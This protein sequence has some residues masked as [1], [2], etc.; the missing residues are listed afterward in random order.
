MWPD[1]RIAEGEAGVEGRS[2]RVLIVHRKGVFAF[3]GGEQDQV[4]NICSALE[5]LG[6]QIELADSVPADASRF[7]LV[8]FFGLDVC[9]IEEI[10][11][12]GGVP[13]VLTPVFWDR[14]QGQLMDDL[15]DE[16]PRPGKELWDKLIYKFR[17]A[18]GLQYRRIA[19]TALGQYQRNLGNY[20]R[21]QQV[22]DSVDIFLP[23]SEAEMGMLR[24]FY[25]INDPRYA[26]VPNAV[27]VDALDDVSDFA[28]KNLRIC[29]PFI[30][31]SGGI[32]RRKNQ[33]VLLKALLNTDVPVVFAGSVRDRRYYEAIVRLAARRSGV[34]FLGHLSRRDLYSVL[35]AAA[36]HA[37]PA[38]H[39]TP[40]IANLEAVA[41]GC[42]N[43]ATQIGGLREYLGEYS[44]YCNPFSLDHIRETVLHALELSPDPEG[45][46]LVRT[47]YTYQQAAAATFDAY[48]QLLG[49]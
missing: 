13:K 24:Q 7:D 43:V 39:D 12:A 18:S 47:R 3:E 35:K 44:L 20:G 21:F 42:V 5:K 19:L 23:N 26:V 2:L 1:G 14:A 34:H 28:E 46:R 11:R 9:H 37:L 31:C 38:F 32:D 27:D 17:K 36:V 6:V 8:H 45:S 16:W 30:L 49:G 41:H 48:K 40:G 25:V 10:Q 29:S 22:I 15:W 33:Y 4:R